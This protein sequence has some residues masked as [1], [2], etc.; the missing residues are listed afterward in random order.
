MSVVIA[1]SAPATFEIKSANLPLVALRLKSTDL[2]AL[3]DDL[4]RQYGD[5]PDFFDNEP[6]VIDLTP[7][8][9]DAP[10][11]DFAALVML[12]QRFH[13]AP[14]AFKGGNADHAARALAAG[15][16]GAPDLTAVKL[17]SQ[18]AEQVPDTE[19]G[20][21][22]AEPAST[23]AN[24]PALVVDKPLRSGQQVY[25]RGRDLVMLAMVN[26]GAEVIA[27]GHIHV[28]A[29]LR[30]KAIAGARGNTDARIFALSLEPE[31]ISIAGI[32]R[33]TENALPAE[34]WGQPTQVRLI[35][36]PDGDRLVM[37][38]LKS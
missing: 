21:A 22:V 15:L 13:L 8:P 11:I 17:R 1:G 14:I 31:L 26:A 20:P 10:G 37:E 33:T 27:D 34:V 36:G 6:L 4:A 19:P 9:V 30:G 7:L 23:P 28:Y 24:L 18:A 29:P 25:A 3:A 32:Y 38:P 5:M 2:D 12:L 35:A 16:V